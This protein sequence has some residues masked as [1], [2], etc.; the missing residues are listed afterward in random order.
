MLINTFLHIPGVGEHIEKKL[1]KHG[2]FCWEDFLTNPQAYK[3]SGV[4]YDHIC[5][6]VLDSKENMDNIYFFKTLMPYKHYWRLF[7]EF[8]HKTAYLD[9]ETTGLYGKQDDITVI[10]IYDGDKTQS[11]V[12]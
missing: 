11:F 4:K 7:K 12:H 10:G 2:I 1:C 6:Y 8:E 3:L 5:R 9:I